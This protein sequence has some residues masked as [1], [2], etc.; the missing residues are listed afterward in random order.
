MTCYGKQVTVF[1]VAMTAGDSVNISRSRITMVNVY[2]DLMDFTRI[3]GTSWTGS[4]RYWC[5]YYI[6]KHAICLKDYRIRSFLSIRH[7]HGDL[8]KH[9]GIDAS[10]D[11]TDRYSN[12]FLNAYIN[13]HAHTHLFLYNINT[14]IYYFRSMK[15]RQYA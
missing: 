15:Y 10:T 9:L 7:A 13:R 1:S 6:E 4:S 8:C 3:A 12:L 11:H 14:N 5:L 2:V